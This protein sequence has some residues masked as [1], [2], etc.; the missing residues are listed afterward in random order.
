MKIIDT[1]GH[2]CPMPIIMVKSAI[3]EMGG[4]YA[5]SILTDNEIS[6]D[7]LQSF[8]IDNQALPICEK[9]GDYWTIT[10]G[11]SET[12]DAVI[13]SS[14]ADMIPSSPDVSS[15]KSQSYVIAVKSDKMGIGNDELGAILVSGFFSVIDAME[16]LP[17]TIIFYNGGVLLTQK[18]SPVISS[19]VSLSE[20][21]VDIVIC[22]ACVDFY[23]IK[24]EIAIGRISN[25][26]NITETLAGCD[27]VI[28]P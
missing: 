17:T 4:I 22:G 3:K 20:R 18:S 25:M 7:N 8:F 26:Y 5:M 6:R 28:Y 10:V 16:T 23:G 21:N 27:K 24:D 9:H 15:V 19:L 1:R 13:S 11:E 12:S 14:T 2:L